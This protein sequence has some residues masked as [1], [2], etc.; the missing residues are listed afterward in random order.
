MSND[1]GSIL[2][3]GRT[4]ADARNDKNA[5][6]GIVCVIAAL[7]PVISITAITTWLIFSM[8]RIRRSVIF[9]G[10]IIYSG[11]L[12]LATPL[13]NPIGLYIQSWTI[14]VPLLIQK[15]TAQ[16]DFV[17]SIITIL[18]RQAPVSVLI[19]GI[20]GLLYASHAWSK[21]AEWEETKFRLTPRQW[22]AKRKNIK[23]IQSNTNSPD[24]GVTLGISKE[25]GK[26]IIQTDDQ[27]AAH[28]LIFGA[29]G[30]GK[31]TTVMNMMRDMIKRG[32][33]VVVIDLKGGIDIP[34]RA[35]ELADREG[36]TFRHWTMHPK[37]EQYNGPSEMGPAFY[38]P[39]SRGEPTR[40]K[41]LLMAIHEWNEPYYK[42]LAEEY[43]QKAFEIQIATPDKTVSTIE[44]IASLFELT[45]LTNRANRLANMPQHRSMIE[46]INRMNDEKQTAQEKSA[47]FTLKSI[48]RSLILSTAGHWLKKD[49]TGKNNI[50]LKDVAHNSE[51]VVFSLDSSTY[52]EVA[53]V[54]G[55]LIIQDLKTV[56]SE[57]RIN[58]APFPIH[59]IIDEF[60]E[61]KSNNAIQLVN[62]A[63]DARMPVIL[64]T[65]TLGDLRAISDS[66]ADQL[67]GVVNAFI[68]HRANTLEDSKDFAGL[69]G[70]EIKKKFRQSV[71]HKSSAF[72]FGQGSGSGS[73]TIEDVEDFRVSVSTFQELQR[74]EM[75]W[76]S[77]APNSIDIV[78]VIP[79]NS[80]LA[81]ATGDKNAKKIK[82]AAIQREISLRKEEVRPEILGDDNY[83]P[84]QDDDPMENRPPVIPPKS[85]D[86]ERLQKIFNRPPEEFILTKET[87]GFKKHHLPP[88]KSS[89][90]FKVEPPKNLNSPIFALPPKTSSEAPPLPPRKPGLPKRPVTPGGLPSAVSRPPMPPTAAPAPLP[91]KRVEPVNR[92]APPIKPVFPE[93]D[94][95]DF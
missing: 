92:P 90:T 34:A 22:F 39:I 20:I 49:P 74:G 16:E 15:I 58:P 32:H 29:S 36:K 70:L 71:D 37:N 87:T 62:K 79:E 54:L 18:I 4:E 52:S 77:K 19:G 85:S 69:T 94:K 76:V 67:L 91:S 17:S 2:P 89:D 24:N 33:G 35:K 72:G 81:V 86:P 25:T 13:I 10:L 51:V 8:G 41:D 23:D 42:A 30:S 80:A 78:K 6:I 68:I 65:Q 61:L 66:F 63:R 45:E 12:L 31:T 64:A 60:A 26:K 56:T 93:K 14:G 57:L 40:R 82:P 46:E 1:S 50:N 27:A 38:D 95:F 9:T 3:G 59:I 11:L 83:F 28:T 7:V 5:V 21:K 47:I 75:V 53:G 84:I 43:L 73:G 44:D 55:N 88:Q 48:I